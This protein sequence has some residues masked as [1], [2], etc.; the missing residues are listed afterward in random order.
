M[1]N[2]DSHDKII[3]THSLNSQND[4]KGEEEEEE[5]S[6][7]PD[8]LNALKEFLQD[9]QVETKGET[10]RDIREGLATLFQNDSDSDS[11]GEVKTLIE[12][13]ER[14][15][16]GVEPKYLALNLHGARH[17]LWG[18][19]LW[20]AAR[21]LADT[22]DDPNFDLRGKTTLELGAGAGLPSLICALNGAET[23]VITDYASAADT[24]LVENLQKNIDMLRPQI[25]DNSK[26]F[27]HGYIWGYPSEPLLEYLNPSGRKFD[28]IILADLLFNHSE[29]E[30]LL[31]TC[32]ACL[33]EDGTIWVTYGHHVPHK[34]HMDMKFFEYATQEP[35]NFVSEKIDE[36]Q[37]K[38]IIE[39][40]DGLDHIRGVVY[41]Y[42]LK[43]KSSTC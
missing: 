24:A 14:K 40:N 23:V 9:K 6:F 16:E 8:T 12:G 2:N 26:V 11:E 25:P 29:H 37:M 27:A 28:M 39:E 38:D 21:Y 34:A 5:L 31:Q 36:I 22:F 3:P 7:A 20:N 19:R 33:S 13:Y 41:T 32:D 18:H 4:A 1:E 42:H 10:E 15:V 35:F 30:K 43:R 17:S